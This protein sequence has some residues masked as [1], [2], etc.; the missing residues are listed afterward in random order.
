MQPNM[1]L[2]MNRLHTRSAMHDPL[3]PLYIAPARIT[4]YAA[5]QGVCRDLNNASV[6]GRI[7]VP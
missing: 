6:A 3:E 7:V 5:C 4:T 1:H 2:L